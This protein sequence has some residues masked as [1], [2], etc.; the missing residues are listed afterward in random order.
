MGYVA[1]GVLLNEKD[2]L[3]RL[4][5]N[6]VRNDV[7][8]RNEAF[9][10]LALEF[11]AN[12][13]GEEF[14]QLLTLDV[15]NVITNGATRP[16][17]RKKAALC[18]LRMLRNS[19]ADSD[20]ISASEWGPRMAALLEERDL[21]VLL[22]LT[23]LL[24]GI[25][26]RSFEGYEPCV[27]RLI[28]ILDRLK[29]RDVPQDYTYYGLPSPWLQ[30]KILRILQYFPPP[31]DPSILSSLTDALK[32]ILAGNDPVK[33]PNKSNAVHAIAFEA[34]AVA[35]ALGDSELISL[36]LGLMARFLTVREANLRYLALENFSRL[37]SARDVAEA[38]AVHQKT[39]FSCLHDK[40]SSIRR[41]A[42]DLMFTTATQNSAASIVDELLAMLPRA[43]FGMREEI[44]LKA[45]ILAERFPPSHEWYVDS[46]L[47]LMSCAIDISIDDIWHSV[48]QLVASDPALH[49][50]AV[51]KVIDGL[52]E[53]N[54]TEP[55]LRCAA[56]ILGEHGGKQDQTPPR[57]QFQLLNKRFPT[58]T[59]ATKAM[60]LSA[61]EKLKASSPG[62]GQLVSEVNEVLS[63]HKNSIDADIQQ[64]ALEY[65]SLDAHPT[66]AATA[67]QPLP[68][69]EKRASLLLRRLAEREGEG[70]DEAKE[71]PAWMEQDSGQEKPGGVTPME[72]SSVVEISENSN[73]EQITNAPDL[74]D[75]L[76]INDDSVQ[77]T[78]APVAVETGVVDPLAFLQ[79]PAT[80]T[81][82]TTPEY[83]TSSQV[84]SSNPFAEPQDDKVAN[85]PSITATTTAKKKIEP[86]GDL[87]AWFALLC[88]RPSGVLYE[89][90]N[91]Q[92]G[93]RMN[94]QGSQLDMGVYLGNKSGDVL[95]NIIFR[96]S[97]PPS[98]EKSLI[99]KM[100][101]VPIQLEPGKQVHVPVQ[102]I[103]SAPFAT[104][105]E[106]HFAYK[107]TREEGSVAVNLELPAVLTKYCQPVEVPATVFN[108]RWSQVGGP[109]FKLKQDVDPLT[110][111]NQIEAITT[112]FPSIHIKVLDGIDPTPGTVSGACVLHCSGSQINQIPCMVKIENLDKVS[113]SCTITVATAD[114]KVSE[115]LLT[116][117]VRLLKTL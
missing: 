70:A 40:D 56:F 42:L 67:L 10:C 109:P 114:A 64:R 53:D 91:I 2:E 60:L 24:L 72:P 73:V 66:A 46:M 105:P 69:W 102:I 84:K 74:L 48:V 31:D 47:R 20:M 107:T 90:S 111:A 5:V 82:A 51:T 99:I 93:I 83:P 16:V 65:C 59:P 50:Y 88:Q 8:S 101:P 3:L 32:R 30:V 11:I 21:G 61:Y 79:M 26:S 71:T 58:A 103:C 57:E 7:L 43:D 94:E 95:D 108:A 25:V 81:S 22:G 75:L 77:T 104:I 68:P 35:L 100:T 97:M 76:D 96:I 98:D 92:I 23:T 113:S 9:Q 19:A 86:T 44:V 63:R 62:D 85:V 80:S 87:N 78:A 34:V 117:L 14:A 4:V 116:L 38:V 106:V 115:G 110:S 45:A 13:G 55:Y 52:K 33:N 54:V 17:V 12:V 89:D 28:A 49:P 27:P 18:L 36:G 41:R 112:L 39:V 37:A 29:S 6:S 1:C 15:M